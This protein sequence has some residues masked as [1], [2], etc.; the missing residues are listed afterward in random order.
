M[1]AHVSLVGDLM[2]TCVLTVSKSLMKAGVYSSG[3]MVSEHKQWR[4]NLAY[5]RRLDDH[6]NQLIAGKGKTARLINYF[7]CTVE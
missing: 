7:E 5:F 6:A 4:R 1:A 3:T 2:I